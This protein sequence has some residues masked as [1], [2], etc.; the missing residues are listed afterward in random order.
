M[1]HVPK[2]VSVKGQLQPMWRNC[3]RHYVNFGDVLSIV[4]AINRVCYNHVSF[5]CCLFHITF[6]MKGLNWCVFFLT[7]CLNVYSGWDLWQN[8]DEHSWMGRWGDSHTLFQ[9]PWERWQQLDRK[10]AEY[11]ARPLTTWHV[12]QA[13]YVYRIRGMVQK[14]HRGFFRYLAP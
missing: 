7:C 14:H 1:A 3:A 6:L 11:K 4:A 5:W 8:P 13:C 12:G 2:A 10:S 9:E